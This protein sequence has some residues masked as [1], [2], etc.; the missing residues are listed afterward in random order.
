MGKET[1]MDF[2]LENLPAE[3]GE[4][5]QNLLLESKFFE[6]PVVHDLFANPDEYEYMLTIVA[7]NS[8]HTVHVSD[9]SMPKTLRPLIEE[10]TKL[11]R[12]RT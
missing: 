7:G 1:S 10:L 4:R 2:E 3:M 9:T 11:A 8:L 6:I 12:A 5:L